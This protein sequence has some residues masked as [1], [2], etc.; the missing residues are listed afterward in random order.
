MQILTQHGCAPKPAVLAVMEL[1]DL[2]NTARALQ[3]QAQD[4]GG[5][6]YAALGLPHVRN[7]GSDT[8]PPPPPDTFAEALKIRQQR[9][10]VAVA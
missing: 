9:A 3:A 1:E 7:Q 6:D 10:G 2:E 8:A 5:A 4:V